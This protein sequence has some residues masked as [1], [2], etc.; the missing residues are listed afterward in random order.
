MPKETDEY[1][2]TEGIVMANLEECLKTL[3]KGTI[4]L[5]HSFWEEKEA[6]RQ[7]STFG[8]NTALWR[9][10]SWSIVNLLH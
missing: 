10:L 3:L 5:E 4:I 9:Y 7:Y 2:K 8:S 6:L 1:K